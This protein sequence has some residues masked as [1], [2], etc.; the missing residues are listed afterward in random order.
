MCALSIYSNNNDSELFK[1][2]RELDRRNKELEAEIERLK[3][4]DETPEKA[5]MDMLGDERFLKQLC[6]KIKVFAP[7]G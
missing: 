5:F 4:R 2:S 6:E 1:K 3:S 7:N